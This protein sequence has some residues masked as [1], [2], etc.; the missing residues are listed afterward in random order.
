MKYNFIGRGGGKK[1]PLSLGYICLLTYKNDKQDCY[2][3]K[4]HFK[5]IKNTRCFIASDLGASWI[6]RSNM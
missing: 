5:S 6:D 4:L 2:L 1:E 3:I